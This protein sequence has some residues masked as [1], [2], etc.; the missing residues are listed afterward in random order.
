MNKIESIAK[1]CHETN[2]AYCEMLGDDSQKSWEEAP[3]WQKESAVKGVQFHLDNP[4]AKPSHSHE[5]WLKEKVNNGWSY[6]KEKD[7]DKRTHPC[8][9]P[10]EQLP[11][12]QQVKDILFKNIVDSIRNLYEG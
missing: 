8:I 10:F 1:I 3:Q 2:K 12:E 5:S 4:D 9:V 6:G 7:P 11:K